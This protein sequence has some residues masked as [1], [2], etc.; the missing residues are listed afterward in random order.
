MRVPHVEWPAWVPTLYRWLEMKSFTA[1]ASASRT[2]R[3]FAMI[4]SSV[5]LNADGSSKGP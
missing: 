5:T 4:S 2:P 1:A 3:S